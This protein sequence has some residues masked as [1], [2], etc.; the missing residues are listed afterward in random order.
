MAKKKITKELLDTFTVD[1]N[2]YLEGKATKV[3]TKQEVAALASEFLTK[4]FVD[5]APMTLAWNAIKNFKVGRGQFTTEKYFTGT[6][7]STTTTKEASKKVTKLKALPA[8]SAPTQKLQTEVT[9]ENFIPTKD[10]LYVKDDVFK[11]LKTVFTANRFFPIY[12]SGLSGIGKTTGTEQAAA[13]LKR[14]LII[15]S[16]TGETNEDDLLGGF[17]LIDGETV[18]FDGPVVKAMRRGAI[19][20]LDEVDLASPKIMALQPVLSG[21]GIFLKKINQMV[22]PAEGFTIVATA[23]TKGQG[24]DTGKFIGTGNLNE[25][26]LDRFP[27]SIDVDYPKEATEVKILTKAWELNGEVDEKAQRIIKTLVAWANMTRE[28]YKDDIIDD[29]I[30]V[31]RLVN[32]VNAIA[33]FGSVKDAIEKTINRFDTVT[34]EALMDLYTKIDPLFGEL[35]EPVKEKEEVAPATETNTSTGYTGDDIPF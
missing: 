5:V 13:E 24:D 11:T 2:T 3:V 26:F 21:K 10:K 25:A 27:V 9:A 1:I 7:V 20:L 29:V 12:I 16:V 4:N 18:W 30:N 35:P 19:L 23:N 17:R 34:K 33:I 8:V 32:V 6:P 31:R 22:E 15:V 28:S 14:E